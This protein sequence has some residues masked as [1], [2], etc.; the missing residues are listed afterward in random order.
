MQRRA[1]G[2]LGPGWSPGVGLR[3]RH[4]LAT[5]G[6]VGALGCWSH[7]RGV[8]RREA[9]GQLGSD[10]EKTTEC[11]VRGQGMALGGNGHDLVRRA[12]APR[13]DFPEES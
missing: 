11:E 8:R 9:L 3:G 1:G 2:G 7:H 13:H 12:V 10:P 6:G 4:A 5:A